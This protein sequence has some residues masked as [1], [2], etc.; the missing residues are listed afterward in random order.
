MGAQQGQVSGIPS[1]GD[2]ARYGIDLR[3]ADITEG[4]LYDY[5]LYL[6]AGATQ[7]NFFGV[8]IGQGLSSHPGNAGGS[9][10]LAD[11]NM[12]LANQLPVGYGFLVQCLEVDFS[13][14]SVSTANTFT[15]VKPLVFNATAAATTDGGIDD[16]NTLAVSGQ[17]TFTIAAKPEVEDAPL[18]LF[19]P[20]NRLDIAGAVSMAGTNAQPAVLAALR[21]CFGGKPYT[22]RI[23]KYINQQL[24]FGVSLNFPVA[25]ATPSGFNGRIGCRLSGLLVRPVQ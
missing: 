18:G 10:T 22:L 17:L 25:Q 6:A 5:Q 4:T 16:V 9:K 13:A 14:G 11:T 12:R 1:V 19:P 3:N 21:A 23:P 8:P 7:Y 24:N 20:R 15:P 2:L